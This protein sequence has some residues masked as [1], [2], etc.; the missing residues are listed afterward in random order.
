MM[1]ADRFS[2][3]GHWDDA[4]KAYRF[5]LA[6]FPNNAAAIIG[7]GKAA[8]TLNQIEIAKK[9]FMQALKINPSNLEALNFMADVQERSGQ[10]AAASETYLRMGNVYA[11]K[12]D[13]ETA[14]DYWTRAAQLTADHTDAHHKLAEALVKQGRSRA[15][16]REFLTLAAI[17]QRRGDMAR[18]KEFINAANELTPGDP[19]IL[20]AREA[21]ASGVAINPT[22]LSEEAVL[23]G[24]D[25][26]SGEFTGEDYGL[27]DLF[28]E[29]EP[30]GHEQHAVGGLVEIARQRAMEQLA[31]R[32]FE[33]SDNP[34]V[35]TIM[36]A[37]DFQS[38]NDTNGA[39]NLY[40]QAINGGYKLPALF[41][42]LGMLYR[43]QGQLSEAAQNLEHAA[44]DQQFIAAAQFM[45]GDT[46][47]VTNDFDQA[48]QH[49]AQ[50][51]EAI[52]LQTVSGHRSYELAQAYEVFADNF[53]A[54]NGSDQ[55]RQFITSVQNFFAS[56]T[57]E[58]RV[59]EA[60]GR[61]NS[62]S[63]EDTTMSLAEF[64][65]TPETEV[66]V[67]TLALTTEYMRQNFLMTAS[68]EC[69]RA[70]Q[71]VPSFLPLHG[72]LAEIMLKQNRTD[73]AITKYLYIAKVYQMRNQ[74]DQSVTVFQKILKLA[75][76]DVT[77]RSKLIDLYTSAGSIDEALEQYLILADSYYQLAQ[78]DR[79]I[80]KYNEAIR[81]ADSLQN[82]GSW[83]VEA[84]TRIAD[85][86]NQRFDWSRATQAMLQLLKISPNNEQI[87]R[88]LVELHYKQN[89]TA[90]AIKILDDLLAIYQRKKPVAA[91][92]LLKDLVEF[93]PGDMALRQRLAVTYVQNNKIREAI[94]EYDAL[95]EMQLENGLRDEAIQTVQAIINL[96]PSDIDG[97]RRLL[98]QIG[99]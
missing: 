12:N 94:T 91:L 38:R 48:V 75:P 27:D 26:L 28:A 9:A 55:I 74:P 59:Y 76:M 18:V 69:L 85:I 83:K 23:P 66:M 96:N 33:D 39:I 82:G 44:E 46:Y 64:L 98:A 29:E 57:W 47:Y 16:A 78:V 53:L 32:I 10:F 6:E 65:E 58:Q 42:N 20:A 80:E 1:H 68:E 93:Y 14:I 79:A 31:N 54:Q 62:L 52:D 3:Q 49:L 22:K 90:E 63:D 8:L 40:R 41:F 88:Q 43:E 13:A 51:I 25:E 50:A 7:F 81:L 84:L 30:A 4:M 35:M 86:Y 89:K 5:A 17:H 15:A 92:D 56:P 73:D 61:M 34:H 99:G 95:G 87:M 60:R 77:V 11:A 70:I 36:Q 72:R 97:Y 37:L 21:A 2:E 71:K 24:D 67:T 19:G 45:L